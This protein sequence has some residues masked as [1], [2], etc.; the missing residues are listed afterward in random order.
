MFFLMEEAKSGVNVIHSPH[1]AI[2]FQEKKKGQ[3]QDCVATV[4]FFV[5]KY[6]QSEMK[7]KRL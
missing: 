2:F 7:A 3:K 1:D 5:L 4:F 6:P